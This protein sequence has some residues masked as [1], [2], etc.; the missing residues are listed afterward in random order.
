MFTP[1]ADPRLMSTVAP[2]A[3]PTTGAYAWF[4]L[5]VGSW[6]AFAVLAVTS[7]DTLTSVWD[8]VRG[9][10]LVLELVVWFLTFPW[11]LA[12]AVWESAWSDAARL[13]VV[14]AIATA[15]TL[16]SIPR[17]RRKP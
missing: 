7:E 8:W 17:P 4:G 12:L 11:M 14:L 16:M 5:M 2:T 6:L 13:L 3:R 1:P 15:W 9:L 10:P